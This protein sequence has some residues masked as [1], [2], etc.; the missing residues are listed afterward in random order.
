MFCLLDLHY[1]EQEL[2]LVIHCLPVL[3]HWVQLSSGWACQLLLTRT[4]HG[5]QLTGFARHVSYYTEARG[6]NVRRSGRLP[7]QSFANTTF[8]DASNGAPRWVIYVSWIVTLSCC[9]ACTLQTHG[10]AC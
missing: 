2:E 6:S 1:T 9:G 10:L 7:I 5:S 4:A 8:P 3:A